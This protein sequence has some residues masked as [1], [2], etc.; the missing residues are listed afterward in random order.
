MTIHE[1]EWYGNSDDRAEYWP[2]SFKQNI[3]MER[4]KLAVDPN[5]WIMDSE[6]TSHM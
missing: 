6:S 4:N 3:T 5:M 1:D 2:L